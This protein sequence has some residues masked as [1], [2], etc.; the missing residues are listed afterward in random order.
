MQTAESIFNR[1]EE[2]R[3][4]LPKFSDNSAAKLV[5][6]QHIGNLGAIADDFDVFL[7]DAFGVLNVGETAIHG[8]S[9]RV[10]MLQKLGKKVYIL[11]NSASYEKPSLSRK[12]ARLGFEINDDH[13]ISSREV[14]FS[15]LNDRNLFS[16]REAKKWGII[17]ICDLG[18]L[19]KKINTVI[20]QPDDRSEHTEFFS[21][22]AFIFLSS[23]NWTQKDQDKFVQH[24]KDNPKPVFI[25]NPDLVAPREDCFSLEPGYFAHEILDMTTSSIEFY[26]KPFSDAFRIAIDHAN[27]NA[28]PTKLDRILMIGDTLHTDIIGGKA[29]K[30]KT[31]LV[32]D[33]GTF[34]GQDVKPYIEKSQIIP[35]FILPSI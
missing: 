27:N 26:G 33:H 16:S 6:P 20:Y 25:G 1:Y 32:T 10:K 8:A 14:L 3:A 9:E 35:D 11:T 2:I 19:P 21:A 15:I 30:I 18:D 22:D 28:N 17:G 4:R 13:I 7:F 31:A 24:L 29:A 5:H 12:F 23:A 34:S